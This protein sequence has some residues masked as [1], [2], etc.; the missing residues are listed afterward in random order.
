MILKDGKPYSD[1]YTYLAS[2]W[3]T[4]KLIICDE[5]GNYLEV[6]DCFIM[7][8]ETIWGCNTKFPK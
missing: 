6:F 7:E 8:S 4:P 3:A 5:Q 1:D 2:T